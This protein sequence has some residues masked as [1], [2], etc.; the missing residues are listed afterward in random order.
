MLIVN[1]HDLSSPELETH[2]TVVNS[3][4]IRTPLAGKKPK[5]H[6]IPRIS[7]IS[8]DSGGKCVLGGNMENSRKRVV[9]S[10]FDH[11]KNV[12]IP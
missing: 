12:D 7:S 10:D 9:L 6:V 3:Y 4:G 5:V 1:S 8:T 2:K 11:F